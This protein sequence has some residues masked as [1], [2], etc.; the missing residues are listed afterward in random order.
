MPASRFVGSMLLR[1][2]Q[3]FLYPLKAGPAAR[4]RLDGQSGTGLA[5]PIREAS[6]VRRSP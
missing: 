6:A 5:L 2:R 1:S 3:T 4:R